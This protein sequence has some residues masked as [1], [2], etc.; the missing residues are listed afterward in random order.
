MN[1]RQYDVDAAY[2]LQ[3]I[4]NAD[5]LGYDNLLE[6]GQAS[7]PD[8]NSNLAQSSALDKLMADYFLAKRG[9]YAETNSMLQGLTEI[10]QDPNAQHETSSLDLVRLRQNIGKEEE[11]RILPTDFRNLM[12][13]DTATSRAINRGKNG[14]SDSLKSIN[15]KDKADP[16]HHMTQI[17][18][19]FDS[20]DVR[21]PPQE[22]VD[23]AL[24]SILQ[25][26]FEYRGTLERDM[27]RNELVALDKTLG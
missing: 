21:K 1:H 4:N 7:S 11:P 8:E 19:Y 18:Q 27:S 16:N 9:E 14:L 17:P 12:D 26:C 6:R 20:Y 2:N 13:L 23:D 5:A 15:I 25:Q 24:R 10:F 22:F 3:G